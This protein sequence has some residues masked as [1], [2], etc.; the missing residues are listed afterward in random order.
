MKVFSDG[1]GILIEWGMI[2]LLNGYMWHSVWGVVQLV[3][4]RIGGDSVIDCFKKK[5]GYYV[6]QQGE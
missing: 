2:A 1:L 6:G 3:D 4:Y 5:R